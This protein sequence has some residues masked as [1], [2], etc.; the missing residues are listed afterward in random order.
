MSNTESF[1]HLHHVS[2]HVSIVDGYEC[3]KTVKDSLRDEL[4]IL[5]SDAALS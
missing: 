3:S 5:E 1:L 4:Y 2:A